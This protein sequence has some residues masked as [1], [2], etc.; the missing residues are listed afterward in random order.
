LWL[1]GPQ[2]GRAGPR[3]LLCTCPGYWLTKP[4][5]LPPTELHCPQDDRELEK[6]LLEASQE[7]A[8]ETL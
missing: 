6:L 3:R 5:H 8:Q 4:S 1:W 7:A 2:L